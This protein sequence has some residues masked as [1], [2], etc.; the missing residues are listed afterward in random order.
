MNEISRKSLSRRSKC[1]HQI[2][3]RLLCL[4]FLLVSCLAILPCTYA[5]DNKQSSKSGSIT[6]ANSLKQNYYE[7]FKPVTQLDSRN[8]DYSIKNGEPWLIEF[9]AP[10]CSHCKMFEN[11]YQEI[12]DTLR[13][14]HSDKNITVAKV[15]GSSERAL[16]SRFK[17]RH[18][19]TF[20]LI[21]GWN[22]WSYGGPRTRIDMVK[23]VT[24]THIKSEV[25]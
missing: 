13:Q 23:F 15:N 3:M 5:Y 8:F 2:L 25:S 9:Y 7:Q 20:F 18:Y 21:Q 11:T 24:E 4:Q 17:V 10:W 16:A 14:W 19:P 6:D 22:I 1:F 12:S